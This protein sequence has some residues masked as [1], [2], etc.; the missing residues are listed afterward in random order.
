M[1]FSRL[2]MLCFPIFTFA[3]FKNCLLLIPWS[4]AQCKFAQSSLPDASSPNV[5]VHPM[6]VCQPQWALACTH[7]DERHIAKLTCACARANLTLRG[8]P[9]AHA[10]WANLYGGRTC[11]MQTCI[12]QTWLCK[13]A[14]GELDWANLHWAKGRRPAYYSNTKSGVAVSNYFCHWKMN[15]IVHWFYLTIIC[16]SLTFLDLF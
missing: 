15:S 16:L 12:R 11:I 2:W 1:N 10:G 3:L 6:Q 9:S 4:F 7:C 13:L 8:F 14:L 5:Q